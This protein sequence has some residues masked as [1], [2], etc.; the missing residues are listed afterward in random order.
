[1][2]EG[3]N[4]DSNLCKK[5][6]VVQKAKANL[7]TCKKQNKTSGLKSHICSMYTR[8]KIYSE[9]EVFFA[10]KK[11]LKMLYHTY[12]SRE[13]QQLS[14]VTNIHSMQVC[15]LMQYT[16]SEF[17]TSLC[18]DFTSGHCGQRGQNMEEWFE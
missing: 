18:F 9:Y 10:E 17:K 5:L 3:K 2:D 13:V 15:I 6:E 16:T 1:M 7:L 8:R 11:T 12:V 14:F 4:A